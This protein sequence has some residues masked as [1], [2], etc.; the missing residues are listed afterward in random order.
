MILSFRFPGKS[1]IVL[2]FPLFVVDDILEP[3]ELLGALVPLRFPIS[4]ARRFSLRL[5]VGAL[6]GVVSEAWRS[7]RWRG[8]FTLADVNQDDTEI[9]IRFV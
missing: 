6:A 9:S 8:A 1:R 3:L 4:L 2:P 7:L 5:D